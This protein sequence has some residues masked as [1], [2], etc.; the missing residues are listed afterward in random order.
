[1]TR[2]G[3]KTGLYTSPHLKHFSERIKVNGNPVSEDYIVD[4]IRHIKPAIER[5]NPSFFELT[6]AMAFDYFAKE[7]VDIAVIE[8]GLGGRL[9]ST[10]VI[11]PEVSLIT[12]I[13]YDHQEMLGNTLEEIAFEKAGI[14]KKQVPVVI[15]EKDAATAKVF[16]DVARKRKASLVFSSDRYK[17]TKRKLVDDKVEINV[18]VT[19]LQEKQS[20]VLDTSG[21]TQVKNIPGVL[22]TIDELND[23]GYHIS[24]DHIKDGLKH[25]RTDT[26]LKGR[27]QV[28]N[29]HPLTIADI[30]H[31][32]AGLEDVLRQVMNLEHK[33]IHFILGFTK[34]KD[35]GSILPLFPKKAN[36]T[37]CQANVPRALDAKWLALQA[38]LYDIK[39]QVIPDVNSALAA[40]TE[41]AG[42]ADIIFIGGSTFVVA[43]LENL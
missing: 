2:V 39:G 3:Y 8:V 20:F 27:W 35:I 10:N 6:V 32:K 34:E 28:L 38:A 40:V 24:N 15:G 26:G 1:L 33:K 5:I 12:N 23:R 16:N 36:Y 31:N 41:K 13:S 29:T 21:I 25:Y 9:D 4:F 11:K 14:I 22:G 43:E 19:D 7:A 42:S 37:F 18:F 17:I 30:A